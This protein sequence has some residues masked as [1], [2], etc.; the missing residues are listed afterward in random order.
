MAAQREWFEKDYYQVLGVSKSA[1]EKEITR[2]YRKLAKKFHPDANPG[3]EDKFKEISTAY[4][5]L[6][7]PSKRKEYDEVRQ[8]VASG[9]ASS[10]GGAGGGSPFG[11]SRG[12]RTDPNSFRIDDLGNFGDLF[13]DIFGRSRTRGSTG[14]QRGSDLEAEVHL[15]FEEA[16]FG[17]TTSLNV[18]GEAICSICH[19]SGAAPGTSPVTCKVCK[20][21]G[22]TDENQGLFSFSQPCPNCSGR[23]VLIEKPCP[24]CK[25]SGVERRTREV[26]VRI[27]PGVEQGSKI[28]IKGRGAPGRNGGPPG[29][30]YV[31]VSVA[32]HK[33]FK[34]KGFDLTLSVPISFAEAV[35]GA[36]ITVPTLEAPVS[37]KIPAGTN[38]GKTFRVRGRG[39]P[40]PKGGIGDLLVT[41]E[42]D[43]PSHLSDEQ[44]KAVETLARTQGPSPRSHLS[45]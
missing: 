30:L 3:S 4:D 8:M 22:V 38:S 33:L 13:G 7:D 20:G 40:K 31:N 43:V 12:P 6:H 2:A 1:T 15:S 25:G 26:K 5:V 21:R 11:Y 9:G 28:R 23:G 27:P 39:V 32:P 41:V 24:R 42:I 34:R 37:L 45:V 29:D 35:L 17:L 36:T 10:F 14:A 44:K 18:T 16:A 19:G